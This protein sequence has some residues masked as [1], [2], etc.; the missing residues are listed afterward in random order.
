MDSSTFIEG[1]AFGGPDVLSVGTTIVTSPQ[2]GE[3]LIEQVAIGVNF[4]DVLLRRGEL[5]KQTPYRL[6]LEASGH[7]VAVG[8]GV[9]D[10]A[11]G[12]RVVYAGGPPGAYATR[13]CVPASR[14]VRVPEAVELIDAAAMFFKALTADYL[15]TRLRKLEPGEPVLVHA[16]TGG[17]GSIIVP[18]L[19]AAG[20]IVIGVVG[21][22][23]KR[24]MAVALGCDHV[25]VRSATSDLSDEV[26]S[27]TGGA[28]VSVAYDSIGRDTFDASMGSLRR[29]G[30]LVSYGWASGDVDPISLSKL[31]DSGSLFVTRPTVSHY[32]DRR[33][34]LL[35]GAKRVFTAI[36][37]GILKPQIGMKLPLA[38]VVQAHN[39]ME[40]RQTQGSVVLL[41]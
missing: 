32:T 28:G 41:T 1:Q 5:S 23:S 30:L 39:Q 14:V 21:R 26:R 17:V 20:V 18:L 29:F 9:A 25:L 16:A 33:D 4:I 10:L 19:K 35:A 38:Q 6:G 13:R 11:V 3:V 24:D 22:E 40:Q 31:R 36:N 15:V 37:G 2:P 7:V 34:D 12:D 8:E 27:L